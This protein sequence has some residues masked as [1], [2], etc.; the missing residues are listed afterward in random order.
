MSLLAVVCTI[1]MKILFILIYQGE[2]RDL[3]DNQ[4]EDIN[5]DTVYFAAMPTRQNNNS[6]KK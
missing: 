6:I 2:L 5:K 4:I 3:K 1:V